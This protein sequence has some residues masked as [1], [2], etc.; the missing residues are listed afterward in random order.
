VASVIYD[1]FGEELRLCGGEGKVRR[2]SEPVELETRLL[3]P[4]PLS[5]LGEP[6]T[7]EAADA[8]NR[9]RMP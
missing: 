9:V 4:V 5:K 8:D 7:P 1:P 2:L 6:D 3:S